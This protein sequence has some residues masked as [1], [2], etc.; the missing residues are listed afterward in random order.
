MNVSA[1]AIGEEVYR[2][3][4]RSLRGWTAFIGVYFAC[5]LVGWFA[6]A[7][8][9]PHSSVPAVGASGAIFG[10]WGALARLGTDGAPLAPLFSKQVL[11]HLKQAVIQNVAFIALFFILGLL[12][13][14]HALK[15]AWEA[16][17][18][19]FLAGLV[20]IAPA[21][22]FCERSGKFGQPQSR[23]VPFTEAKGTP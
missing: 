6:F 8:L 3:F 5:G 9:A 14:G 10:L 19:G 7:I 17:L 22:R 16:H 13:S 21:L 15:L 4:G 20:L 23:G 18:G 12:S 1:L 11:T 2:R